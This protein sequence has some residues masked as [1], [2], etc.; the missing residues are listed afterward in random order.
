MFIGYDQISGSILVRDSE[1]RSE[2]GWSLTIVVTLS[3]PLEWS[4]I[5]A[6]CKQR[7]NGVSTRLDILGH[8]VRLINDAFP[9]IS[10]TRRENFIADASS[11]DRQLVCTQRG[12]VDASGSDLPLDGKLA[13][14]RLHRS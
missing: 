6:R 2:C 10:P 5:P 4:R 13:A 11:V 7:A 14:Q 3:K 1:L 8:V 9:E 12:S